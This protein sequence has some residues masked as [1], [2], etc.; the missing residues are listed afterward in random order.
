[1]YGTRKSSGRPRALSVRDE[2]ALLRTASNS[3]L[4]CRQIAAE[5]GVHTNVRNVQ[6][7]LK[8]SESLKRKKLQRRPP[9]TPQH[10]E[11]RMTFARQR[12]TWTEQWQTVL[13]SDEKRFNLDGPDG[14]SYYFHDLR[15]EERYLSRRQMGGGGIMVWAGI[16]YWRK[17][18]LIFIQGRLNSNGYVDL[19]KD[20]LAKHAARIFEP[21]YI[22]QQDNATVH[23][24]N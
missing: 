24:A 21:V 9:L 18:D 15:K 2:R 5:A 20:Q 17:T 4:T 12:V 14:W 11:A 16:G 1:M 7:L 23:T 22:F 19:L 3:S 10:K 13:F 8:K 6:K